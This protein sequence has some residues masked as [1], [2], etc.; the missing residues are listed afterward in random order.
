LLAC[1]VEQR[2]ACSFSSDR[3]TSAQARQARGPRYG[4]SGQAAIEFA[5]LYA[6]AILPLT[7]ML[8]Y[9]SQ[10]LWIWHSVIDFNRAVAQFAATHCWASD[11]SGSNVLSWA[12]AHVPPMIDRDQ[13]Q[14]NAAGLTVAYYSQDSGGDAPTP[15]DGGLCGGSVCVPDLVSVSV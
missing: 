8:V 11:H 7:F 9:V 10:M 15:F 12:A 4:R 2:P 13:F 3:P 14:T 6:A 5:L 1:I